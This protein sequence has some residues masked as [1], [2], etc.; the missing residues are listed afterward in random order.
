MTAIE[1]ALVK[2]ASVDV[3]SKDLVLTYSA[4]SKARDACLDKPE[5]G[6]FLTAIVFLKLC[7][8]GKGVLPLR[9]IMK[10]LTWK[11]QAERLDIQLRF[12]DILGHGYLRECDLENLVNDLVPT[13]SGLNAIQ[14]DFRQFYVY[15]AVRRFMFFLDPRKSGK[16]SIRDL[17]ECEAIQQLLALRECAQPGS[18]WF[19]S[20][21]AINV[22]LRYIEMDTDGNGMLS[23]AELLK[24]PSGMLTPVAV[25]R[26]F[27][28]HLT[29]ENEMDYKGYLDLVLALENKPTEASLGYMWKVFVSKPSSKLERDTLERL[30][31]SVL[32]T[33]SVS[34]P[35][36]MVP[37]YK[38]SDLFNEIFDML[39]VKDR[40]YLTLED[41]R[42]YP[43]VCA[44]LLDAHAFYLYDIRESNIAAQAGP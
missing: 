44:M 33:I 19:S 42:R 10:Y 3:C 40:D 4:F 12:Y 31:S 15:T 29:F 24:Y 7:P 21:S 18:N 39:N 14:E 30:I 43:G 23:Q 8:P 36:L 11:F 20:E 22:Y 9:S 17:I 26:I 16:I 2:E 41:L 38:V 28:E 27:Q 32:S 6:K 1:C 25:E 5:L 34:N 13:L 37:Q 35:A